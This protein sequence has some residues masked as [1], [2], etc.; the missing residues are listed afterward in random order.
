MT[1]F[2]CIL[3]VCA[4]CGLCCL[5]FKHL[6]KQKEIFREAEKILFHAIDDL[7]ESEESLRKEVKD[8]EDLIRSQKTRW[9]NEDEDEWRP[10][11]EPLEARMER[12]WREAYNDDNDL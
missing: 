5:L 4:F 3:G 7:K 6:D 10:G 8:L 9:F 1:I 11:C 2:Y 12:L